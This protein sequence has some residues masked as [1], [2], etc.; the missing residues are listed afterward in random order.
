MKQLLYHMGKIQ[1]HP[2]VSA[3]I[4][5]YCEIR[6]TQKNQPVVPVTTSPTPRRSLSWNLVR[7][8]VAMA[9][10]EFEHM[11]N[12]NTWQTPHS[13]WDIIIMAFWIYS[14]LILRARDSVSRDEGH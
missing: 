9:R 6:Q 11:Q 4:N 7:M 14:G 13:F 12:T 5:N 1:A 2:A 10:F 8:M 3:F